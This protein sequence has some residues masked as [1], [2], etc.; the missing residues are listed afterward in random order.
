MQC[1]IVTQERLIF[2]GEVDM[3]VVDGQE[4]RL[5][6]LPHH[7]PLLTTLKI[8]ELVVRANRGEQRYAIG[9][10]VLEVRPDKVTVLADVAEAS[11]EIDL[12]R[13]LEAKARA[14]KLLTEGIKVTSHPEEYA[15]LTNALLRANV[16]LK[17]AR[18]R[19]GGFEG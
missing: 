7:T 5:G 11:D 12:N 10:G 1:E 6:I 9:G 2:S 3:V 17:I 16:R 13:A 14:E 19:Q 4:G 15:N 8:G 18:R